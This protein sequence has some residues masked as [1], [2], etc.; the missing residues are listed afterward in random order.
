MIYVNA[1][2]YGVDG[3][4]GDRPA[5][6]PSIAAA[7][8][9]PL[10]NLGASMPTGAGLSMAEIRDGARRLSAAGTHASA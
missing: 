4:S 6:A 2:G 10:T 9:I 5:F 3:P 1:P 8:G 7:V